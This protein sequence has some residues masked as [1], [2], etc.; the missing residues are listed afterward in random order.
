[1]S[2]RFFKETQRFRQWWLWLIMGVVFIAM[3]M[4]TIDMVEEYRDTGSMTSLV[5]FFVTMLIVIGLFLIIYLLTLKTKIDNEKIE[6]TFRPFINKPKIFK[7]SDIEK[8][9]VRKYKSIREYGGW[10]IRYRWHSRAYNVSGNYGL[11]L[12][13]KSGKKILIGT[14]KPE[15]LSKFL[16]ELIHRKRED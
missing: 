15:E 3:M 9:Y 12:H 5:I 8:A 2:Y 13:L 6:F 10:G 1:M 16:E 7:W 14:Q 11:Q 4:G